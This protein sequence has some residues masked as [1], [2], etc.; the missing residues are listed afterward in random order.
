MVVTDQEGKEYTKQQAVWVHYQSFKLDLMGEGGVPLSDREE[1]GSTVTSGSGGGKRH[2]C[3]REFWEGS[4]Q[5]VT[6]CTDQ[7]KCHCTSARS[8]GNKQGEKP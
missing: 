8:M 3:P 7:L 1:P 2:I 4:S 5:K 6:Q